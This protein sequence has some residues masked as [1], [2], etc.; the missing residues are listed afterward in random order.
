[1]NRVET[2]DGSVHVHAS[3]LDLPKTPLLLLHGFP[4]S[5][6]DFAEVWD[7]LSKERPLASFDFLGFGLSDKPR[8]FGYSLFEQADVAARVVRELGW[9]RVHLLGHDMGTSVLTELLARRERGLLPFEVASIILTNGSVHVTMAHLTVGQRILRSKAGPL[10]AR[11]GTR[12]TFKAQLRRVFAKKP[13]EA[14]LDAMYD[15]VARDDG[16]QRLPALVRYIAERVRFERRWVGALERLDLPALVAWGALDPVAV[17]PI[18][19]RL[20]R[21]IPG[22]ELVTWDDVG[23]YPQVEDPAAFAAVVTAFLERADR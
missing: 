22:A 6:F 13:P 19:Q 3:S 10:F 12:R 15:L 2:P 23:H 18:G 7:A 16:A 17:L 4:T 8:D 21:E 9:P 11:L 5:S 20:A 1:M 14:I